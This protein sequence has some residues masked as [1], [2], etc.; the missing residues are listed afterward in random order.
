MAEY[1][2]DTIN[3][4]FS[5]RLYIAGEAVEGSVDLYFPKVMRENIMKVFVRLRGSISTTVIIE[6]GNTS[7][8]YRQ[9][10]DLCREDISLWQKGCALYPPPGT[11]VLRLPFRFTLP[12]DLP[13]SCAY[14]GGKWRGVIAYYVAVVGIRASG[15][16]GDFTAQRPFTV[17]PVNIHGANL[18]SLL[19]LGWNG[20]WKSFK[21]SKEIRRGIWGDCS[22]VQVTLALP[23]MGAFPVMTSTP[24]VVNVVTLTKTMG[25]HEHKEEDTIFPE[26]PRQ[27]EG[28]VLV[29]QAEVKVGARGVKDGGSATSQIHAV[30]DKSVQSAYIEP[31]RKVWIPARDAYVAKAGKGQWRQEVTV[32]P[33]FVLNCTPCFKTD[34]LRVK[35]SA[36]C[37]KIC[38][39]GVGNNVNVELPIEIISSMSPPG[40]PWQGPPPELDLPP[41]YFEPEANGNGEWESGTNDRLRRA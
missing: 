38:F 8:T 35:Y 24:C 21:A 16:R 30:F 37:L 5:S 41:G 18:R 25:R 4:A 36:A 28:F 13:P 9:H 22:Q 20:A 7:S 11:H 27:P 19:R 31:L 6:R 15:F 33:S 34:T 17:L 3:L 10:V 26:P 29:L 32:R 2:L 39:P 12:V 40:E 14:R 23:D 1:E